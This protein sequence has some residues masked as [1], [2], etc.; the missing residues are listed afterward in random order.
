MASLPRA[1]GGLNIDKIVDAAWNLVDRE[2]AAALSTRALAAD[3]NVKSPALYWH[4][5]NKRELLSLMVERVLDEAIAPPPVDDWKEQI[6]AMVRAQRQAFLSHRDSGQ[7]LSIAPPTERLRNEIFPRFI[8]PFLQT[9]LSQSQAFAAGG[10]LAGFLLG[11][12][13]YEQHEES[14]AFM[15]STNDPDI[16]F[17]FGL[18]A[19][20]SGIEAIARGHC[21]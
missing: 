21:P 7:I 16:A 11:W 8:G 14:R 17:E 19:F 6:R 9:G 13:I 12:V 5:R 20:I 4:V 1:E 10:A 2:G 15:A 3:L 18:D